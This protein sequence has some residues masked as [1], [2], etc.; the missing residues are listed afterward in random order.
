MK[1]RKRPEPEISLSILTK[2]VE[3]FNQLNAKTDQQTL[4]IEHLSKLILQIQHQ[5]H[6]AL[7]QI[8]RYTKFSAEKRTLKY[9]FEEYTC[10]EVLTQTLIKQLPA[11][12]N[13]TLL[14]P[15]VLFTIN[16]TSPK[17]KAE[18]INLIHSKKA[19][20]V[21]EIGCYIG[22]ATVDLA[23]SLQ[24]N[25]LLYA[26]DPWV[27]YLS[28]SDHNN[29]FEDGLYNQFL[30][31]VIHAELTHKIIPIRKR[32]TEAADFFIEKKIYPEVIYVDGDH[33]YEGVLKDL[34]TWYPLLHK[35]GV[36]CGDD[37]SLPGS[38]V[39]KAVNHF[40]EI[41]NLKFETKATA[42]EKNAGPDVPWLWIIH[43]Q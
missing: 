3:W 10:E 1:T 16:S 9:L 23:S 35:N 2:L 20:T 43:K 21:V 27:N 41:H 30:S 40:C 22:M 42:P 19:K 5:N 7:N 26:I 24:N 33:S 14:K 38:G 31:N 37:Y 11:P 34:E 32:S 15:R 13:K 17:Q 8:Q 18:I 36:I 25:A 39:A 28:S 6:S 4:R 29:D 12:Y